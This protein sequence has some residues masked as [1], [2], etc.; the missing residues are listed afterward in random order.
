MAKMNWIRKIRERQR[1]TRAFQRQAKALHAEGQIDDAKLAEC[2]AASSDYKVMDAA[3]EEITL[4]EG[5]W[6]GFDW[7]KLWQ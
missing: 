7:S 2:M 3:V 6:G 5:M 1:F 4:G